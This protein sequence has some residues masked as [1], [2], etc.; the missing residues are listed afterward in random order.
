[1]DR[2]KDPDAIFGDV[3]LGLTDPHSWVAVATDAAGEQPT[4][5]SHEFGHELLGS[6]DHVDYT[7]NLAIDLM[8]EGDGDGFHIPGCQTWQH[9]FS[10]LPVGCDANAAASVEARN[11]CEE[12][13]GRVT[14]PPPAPTE[15]EPGNPLDFLP[16][17]WTYGR[18]S[19]GG[20]T[21]AL[22]TDAQATEG[23]HAITVPVGYTDIA[24]P[25]FRAADL[26]E[27]GDHL[28]VDV[29]IPS[30]VANPYWVGAVALF[31]DI[32][33]AGIYNQWISQQ[34]LTPLGRGA[35]SALEFALPA[36]VVAALRSDVPAVQLIVATNTGTAGL[37]VDHLRFTGQV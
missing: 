4:T 1:M 7:T 22:F 23:S 34:D 19:W 35:W 5:L 21:E 24:S 37:L 32:P 10:G 14:P 17:R 30:P 33:S 28:S 15:M 13:R 8:K 25:S 16:R 18:F 3:D 26:P 6:Y 29:F 36:S 12:M 31:V 20:V 9:A 11:L 2:C 27:V